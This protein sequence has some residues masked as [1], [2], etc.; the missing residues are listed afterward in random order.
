[1]HDLSLLNRNI[2]VSKVYQFSANWQAR[3]EGGDNETIWRE[4]GDNPEKVYLLREKRVKYGEC[5]REVLE[6]DAISRSIW[7]QYL[8]RLVIHAEY[9]IGL[10][11]K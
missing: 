2:F 3:E 8:L 4:K 10:C 9:G 6:I 5:S 11:H 1:M 7:Q